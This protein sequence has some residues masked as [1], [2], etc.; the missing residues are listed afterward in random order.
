ML[1]KAR[2]MYVHTCT[3][4][5][6]IIASEQSGVECA[7]TCACVLRVVENFVVTYLEHNGMCSAREM[8]EIYIYRKISPLR[9]L[10]QLAHSQLEIASH[11]CL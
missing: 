1:A 11:M 9:R 4:L 5:V 6:H 8:T 3:V 10:G 2:Y 7:C